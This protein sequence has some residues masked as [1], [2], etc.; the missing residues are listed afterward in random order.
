VLA[1]GTGS[2]VIRGWQV[3]AEL[4]AP[5]L[6]LLV[7]EGDRGAPVRDAYVYVRQS[8]P[9]LGSAGRRIVGAAVLAVATSG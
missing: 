7:A 1:E 9:M 8:T 2:V 6:S 4:L 3:T 5:A